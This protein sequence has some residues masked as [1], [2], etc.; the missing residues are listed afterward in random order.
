MT[1]N[2]A[3]I[4]GGMG[5]IGRAISRKLAADGFQIVIIHK[6]TSAQEV[7][8]FVDTLEGKG[9]IACA[10]DVTDVSAV[11]GTIK[12]IIEKYGRIDACVYSAIDTLIRK[13]IIE[14]DALAF[15][16]P[17]D[18]AVFGAHTVLKSVA[19]IMQKQNK[20]RIVGITTAAIE[21][22][23]TSSRMGAYIPAKY[24]LRGLLREYAKELAPFD[25]TVNAVAP[26]FV[27]TA[28]NND[29]PQ[30]MVELVREKNPMKKVVSPEDVANVVA[31]LCS[32]G[33]SSL[34]GLS[35]PVTYG[36]TMN[37]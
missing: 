19:P 2:V 6:N 12:S 33:A 22:N 7:A 17:F 3:L 16:A 10:C 24:A 13:K 34:T 27:A 15:K 9:H 5:G 8:S 11:E 35:I 29:L 23:S 28:L 21:P 25:I 26:G 31:F 36:E 20:G 37:L 32:D 18:V 14:L 1:R 4:V 30:Q